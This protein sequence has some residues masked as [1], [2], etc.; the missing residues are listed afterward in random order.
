[1]WAHGEH[2]AVQHHSKNDPRITSYINVPLD[3][4]ADPGTQFEPKNTKN[5]HNRRLRLELVL[6]ESSSVH[7]VLN[8]L[9]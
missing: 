3:S 5:D 7:T 2:L 4:W 9:S 8:V 1:M 6:I